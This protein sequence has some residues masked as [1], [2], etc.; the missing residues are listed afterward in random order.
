MIQKLVWSGRLAE[1]LLERTA[2]SSGLRR[3]GDYEVLALLRR[4]EPEHLTPVDLADQLM[5]SPS[6]M[7][8]K[9][10]RLESQGLLERQPNSYDRRA[11]N[12]H[13]TDKGKALVD[14]A[15]DRALILYQRLLGDLSD[16]EHR[17]LDRRLSGLLDRL[18]SLERLSH[19]WDE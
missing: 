5:I 18:E 1:S 14:E 6:G 2:I 15:F 4:S 9:I 7:T 8:G 11:I 13:L 17:D 12:L 3:R 19:P 16:D 10:D